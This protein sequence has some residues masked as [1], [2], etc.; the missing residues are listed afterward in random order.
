MALVNLSQLNWAGGELSPKMKGR[1]DLPVY[2]SGAERIVNF[3]S[4]TTGPARF[5]CGFTYVNNTRRHKVA[6]LISFQ[7]SDSQAYLL[8]LTEGYVRWHRNNGVLVSGDVNISGITRANPAVVTAN[9]HGY[10]DGDEVIISGVSGMTQ[11]NNRSFVVAN[12]TTNTF[13][14]KDNYGT[15]DIDSSLFDAYVSGGISQK[16]YELETPYFEED[17]FYL[18]FAQNADTM[19]IVGPRSE[20]RKLTRL[21]LASWSLA[22]FARTDDPFT[23]KKTIS[24][25]TQANPAVVTA[26]SHGF[27]NGDRIY[28]ETVVGMTGV[29]GGVFI[30]G[31]A[32]TN[33]FHLTDEDGN[34]IDTTSYSAYSSG[35]YASKTDLLPLSVC[36]YQGRLL[37]GGSKAYPQSFWGSK[38]LDSSGNPQYD[39]LTVGTNPADG[40][41]FT[42]SPSTGK[43]DTIE[44]LIPT[45]A[46]LAICTYEG[47]SKADG[48]SSGAAITPS[49]INVVPAVTDGVSRTVKP[50]LRGTNLVFFHRS[51]LIM[52]SLEYDVFFNAY[53]SI[54][55]NLSNEHLNESG[56]KQMVFQQGKPPLF[57]YVRNDGVLVGLT[58]LSKENVNG[59]H[60]HS[61]GGTDASFLSVGSMPR[62]D[63]YDQLWVVSEKTINGV[64]SRFVEYA[65]EVP[66]FPIRDDFFTGDDNEE[67]DDS[68][69]RHA[70]FEAQKQ[71]VHLDSSLTYDGSLQDVAIE[72]TAVTGDS[73]SIF[74]ESAVFT[75]S[76][77]GR[78]IWKKAINGSERGR[79]EITAYVSSTQVTCRVLTDFDSI[80]V[81]EA[82]NWYLTTDEVSGL[83]HLDGET[84]GVV[85]D[86]GEYDDKEVIDGTITLDDQYSV[87]HV[88][89]KYT[90]LV[91]SMPIEAGQEMGVA[92][93]KPK[94]INRIGFTFLF[95]LGARYGTSLYNMQAVDFRDISD[96]IGMPPPLF[97][98]E[99][100]VAM[101]DV[102]SEEKVVYVQQTKPLPCMIAC[103]T[104]Y[105]DTDNG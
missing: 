86:G 74:A 18:K 27:S 100:R 4:E 80:D 2:Q 58:Y 61:S 102:T 62:D 39:V 95:T 84:V 48:G 89:L 85:V 6:C 21:G 49:N 42:L 97:S 78:Q 94:N 52:Y 104:P 33:T 56:A 68:D 22:L 55:K 1:Y 76:M 24:G 66:S 54:D 65:A 8:E 9:G 67:S 92:K 29:N 32:T 75:S 40:F 14:L 30:V 31:G 10:S 5:R 50:A 90:G 72:P 35:G 28:I 19:Y 36:F 83:W 37:Y 23:S 7:F 57:W 73:I 98:G 69:Y 93:S 25:I 12:A 71:A 105:V 81:I 79:A 53:N 34:Q 60:R 101:D 26:N 63:Q 20:P 64:T 51:N 96:Y 47:I 77:V 44:D 82:G 46:F 17:L 38:A 70:M 16:I 103:V 99:K 15:N 59:G 43:V 3:I 41:K 45:T 11:V 88:G 91:K 13:S 87:I